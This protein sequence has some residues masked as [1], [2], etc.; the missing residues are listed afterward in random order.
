MNNRE[1]QLQ[2]RL[3]RQNERLSNE[4]YKRDARRQ[5]IATAALG[6]MMAAGFFYGSVQTDKLN[7][8]SRGNA[9]TGTTI[10]HTEENLILDQ[11]P[12]EVSDYDKLTAE[13]NRSFGDNPSVEI[14]ANDHV[15]S[16]EEPEQPQFP[17]QQF[18]RETE[19]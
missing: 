3:D 13:Y 16:P 12:Q 6:T 19:R 15:V 2:T 11:P 8:E 4:E 10:T 5:L 1:R 18:D 17:P 14:S 7:R 9:E